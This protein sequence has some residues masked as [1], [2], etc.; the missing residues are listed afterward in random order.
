M[1]TEPKLDLPRFLAV[2]VEAAKR[3]A[4]ELERWRRQFKVYE[5]ARAD[6]VTDADRASQEIVR[7]YLLAQLPDHAFLGEEE[8]VGKTVDQVRPQAGADAVGGGTFTC[9]G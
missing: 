1:T 6:L 4:A 8:C 2:A 7:E 3:G 9:F 5:K